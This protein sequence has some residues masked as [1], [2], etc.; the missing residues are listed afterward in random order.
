M[1]RVLGHIAGG[2]GV[3]VGADH[4]DIARMLVTHVFRA[5]FDQADHLIHR[6]TWFGLQ[7]VERHA[8]AGAAVDM[9]RIQ[10]PVVVAIPAAGV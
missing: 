5:F 3:E 10:P 2:A 7:C 4:A 1:Q 8:L 9:A 6:V